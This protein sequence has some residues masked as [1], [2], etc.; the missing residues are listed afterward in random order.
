M[1]LTVVETESTLGVRVDTGLRRVVPG[2]AGALNP[3]TA[4]HSVQESPWVE[5]N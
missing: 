3:S 2:R 4:P 1:T 5:H